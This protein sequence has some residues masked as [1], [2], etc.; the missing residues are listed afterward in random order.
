MSR[1]TRK[2]IHFAGFIAL[3]SAP[4]FAQSSVNLTAEVPFAFNVGEI[5]LPAGQYRIYGQKGSPIL[6]LLIENKEA[7]AMIPT[8]SV[9]KLDDSKQTVLKF[10][11]YGERRYFAGVFSAEMQDGRETPRT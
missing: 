10:R 8:T 7:I 11:I 5:W 6:T 3:C 9:P 1:I 4:L 2:L